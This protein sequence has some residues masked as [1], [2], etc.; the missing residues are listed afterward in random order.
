[1]SANCPRPASPHRRTCPARIRTARICS[2]RSIASS[3]ISIINTETGH[4]L[5]TKATKNHEDHKETF[6][7]FVYFVV[8][9]PGPWPVSL[10][11]WRGGLARRVEERRLHHRGGDAV[12]DGF[13]RDLELHL[14]PFRVVR[15]LERGERDH[16]LQDGGPRGRRRLAHL[17]AVAIDRHRDA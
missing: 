17:A 3:W 12:A 7:V 10:S 11:W 6:V 1:M 16:A 9:V 5:S 15:P 2:T 13:D 8:F 14:R 4:G